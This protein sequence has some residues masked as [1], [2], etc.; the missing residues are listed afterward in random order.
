MQE[1]NLQF[2]VNFFNGNFS[3][4]KNMVIPLINREIK[5]FSVRGQHQDSLCTGTHIFTFVFRCKLPRK[6]MSSCLEK[7]RA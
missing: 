3:V 5:K 4:L 1:E 7:P 2:M 6:G